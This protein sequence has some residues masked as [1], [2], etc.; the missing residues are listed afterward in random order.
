M[1]SQ[2]RATKNHLNK[3][4]KCSICDYQKFL[5]SINS[6]RNARQYLSE[7]IHFNYFITRENYLNRI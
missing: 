4:V 6:F 7:I 1:L 3:K 2:I 5:K